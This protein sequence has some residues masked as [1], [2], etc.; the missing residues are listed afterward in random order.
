LLPSLIGKLKDARLSA[1]QIIIQKDIPRLSAVDFF[2][3]D[4]LRNRLDYES[5]NYAKKKIKW[6][7]K[8]V[9]DEIVG[10]A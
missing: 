7:V 10:Y 6:K 1:I 4:L 2:V 3:E 5:I 8:K 9:W